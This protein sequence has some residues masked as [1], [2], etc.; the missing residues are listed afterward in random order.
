MPQTVV[1]TGASGYIAKHVLQRLLARGYSVRAGLRTPGRADAVR[2]AVAPGVEPGALERLSFV[3]LDLDHD[4]GWGAALAGAGA[5]IH[6]A[7]PFP[8][9]QPRDAGALVRPAVEGTRRALTAAARA[10]V[11]RVI[12]TSS[13]AAILGTDLPRGRT[14]HDERDWTDPEHP[15][16]IPY[17]LS[18]TLA[19]REAWAIAA[20]NPGLRL[21]AINP[22][23]VTGPPL[24]ARF[25]TSLHLVQRILRARDPAVPRIAFG[26]VDVRDVAEAHLRA[27]ERHETAG[28]RILVCDRTLWFREVAQAIAAALPDR[29]IVTREAPD[30]LLRLIALADPAVRTV[31]PALGRFDRMDNTKARD[32]LGLEF[33]PA[34]Q[35]VVDTARW[36]VA[37]GA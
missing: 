12:L 34:S 28:E 8:L 7:S 16:V 17:T 32:L 27:L 6:T 29:R 4:A 15:T 10:G 22:A 19:E 33:I 14:T 30:W 23:L 1:L 31:L 3:T 37:N 2:A 26:I 25:G 9:A 5:L 13:V 18:K 11:E 35:S 21:T 24:D 20:A 36:M